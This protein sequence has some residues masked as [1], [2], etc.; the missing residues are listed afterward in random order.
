M[1]KKGENIYKRKDGRWEGRY[2]KGRR[3]N[4]KLHYGY[5][6]GYRYKDVKS[7]LVTLK[8]Y[9]VDKQAPEQNYS[10]TLADWV[11]FYMEEILRSKI[12]PSTYSYY[13]QIL[14][15]HILPE[16]G[17]RK[18]NNITQDDIQAFADSLQDKGI[19]VN[20][21]CGIIGMM[22]RIFTAAIKKNLVLANPCRDL[23]LPAKDIPQ[24]APLTRAEQQKLEN[25]AAADKDGTAVM[26]ALYTGM[27]IG[28]LCALRWDD[29]DFENRII[30]VR[31][32]I[33]RI[34][35]MEHGG[36][37]T[38]LN[39]GST[40]SAFSNRS[41]PLTEKLH[42][43]LKEEQKK[44]NSDYVISCR[45]NIAE[46]RIVRYRY[47]RIL[48]AAGIRLIHFHGLRHTFATRCIETGMDVAALSRLLGH[49]SI[50][51][52]L[53]IYTGATMEHKAESIQ[54]LDLIFD[55]QNELHQPSFES[56]ASI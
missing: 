16:L 23:E 26:L 18:L 12:K 30:N 53:D 42:Q 45:G 4:G 54:K 34:S 2:I 21:A 36:G 29:I 13:H 14:Q 37:K 47:H 55:W 9:Y 33:Q 32:T 44:S 20:T 10:G 50:K 8:S 49:S 40:K 35:N 17:S 39:I 3:I 51:M 46:P 7:R 24:F 1:A 56:S 25:A 22:Q 28:E 38:F 11:Q 19:G 5:V 52:T 43:L 27:R 31:R 48:E 41:I 6:Y 15:N